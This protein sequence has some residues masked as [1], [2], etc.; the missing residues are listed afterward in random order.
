MELRLDEVVALVG[1]TLLAGDPSIRLNGVATLDEAGSSDLTFFGVAKYRKQFEETKAGAVLVTRDVTSGPE[2]VGLIQVDDPSLALAAL[3]QKAVEAAQAFEPGI[4]PGALVDESAE[5]DA[6]AAVHPGAVVEADAVIGPGTEICAG[7]V[8]GRGAKV[9]AGCRL[10]HNVTVREGCILGDR[11]ILQ[12]GVVI[13]SDGFGYVFAG[14]RHQKVPQIGIVVVENDVEIGANSCI[15]RARFGKTVIGEGTKIDNLVQ[16]AHNVQ[17]G[18]HCIVVALTGVAGSAKLHDHVTLGAQVGINGHIEIASGVKV[19]GQSGVQKSLSE[20][21]AYFG[22]PA[23]P[24]KEEIRIW[25]SLNKLPEVTKEVRQLRK[26]V[27]ELK[28]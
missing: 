20:P 10:Y 11:V 2:G 27:D 7:A 1:G 24:L 3:A 5:V 18:K 19:A 15:D 21:G 25:R 28:E 8:I 22:L 16:I 4:R 17:I 9:G 14:G 23:K 12:P 13:G 6:T 26:E